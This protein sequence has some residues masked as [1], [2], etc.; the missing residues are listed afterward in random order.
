MLEWAWLTWVPGA[1]LAPG[2]GREGRV[3]LILAGMRNAKCGPDV[4]SRASLVSPQPT[5]H[6]E[7]PSHTR[8]PGT[9]PGYL[10]LEQPQTKPMGALLIPADL[11]MLPP[12]TGQG[13]AR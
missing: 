10:A 5:P 6:P 3:P 1:G 13:V 2:T 4:Q 8:A 12:E 11:G 9:R 7:T